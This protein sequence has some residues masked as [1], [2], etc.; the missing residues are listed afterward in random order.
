MQ[1]TDVTTGQIHFH[2]TAPEIDGNHYASRC[3]HIATQH[4]RHVLAHVG[5]LDVLARLEADDQRHRRDDDRRR[6]QR[7][8]AQRLAGER[9]AVEGE[10]D[11]I[12]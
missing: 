6:Q 7:A 8:R 11:R 4:R 1:A 9:P 12:L 3:P 2:V 5:I 10:P